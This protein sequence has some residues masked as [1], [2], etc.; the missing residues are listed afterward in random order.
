MKT[1]LSALL[2]L[3]PLPVLAQEET[4]FALPPVSDLTAIVERP[5]FVPSRQATAL[6]AAPAARTA[7]DRRLIGIVMRGGQGAAL[8]LLDGTPR[9]LA[10]GE[11]AADWRLT[12][13]E[14]GA[15]LLSHAD[16]RHLRLTVGQALP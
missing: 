2:L 7:A 4:G 10:P 6:P 12:A 11:M 9:T 13:I 8:L 1:L 15:A 3:T 16:G 14:P 5:L